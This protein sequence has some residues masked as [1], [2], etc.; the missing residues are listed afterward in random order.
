ML[1]NNY[2]L[3][4]C[5]QR[6][7]YVCCIYVVYLLTTFL[8]VQTTPLQAGGGPPRL[9]GALGADEANQET[10]EEV[11]PER[12]GEID[13]QKGDEVDQGIGADLVRGHPDIVVAT[14]GGGEAKRNKQG[15][16]E[17]LWKVRSLIYFLCS[18]TTLSDSRKSSQKD[19]DYR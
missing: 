11:D 1:D 14:L 10:I 4:I 13:R 5:A 2:V 9:V 16:Y 12:G 6:I 15:L 7:Y 19:E 8:P 18:E 17:G 3:S